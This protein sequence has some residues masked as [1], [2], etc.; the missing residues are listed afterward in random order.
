MGFKRR[1]RVVFLG[2]TSSLLP[3]IAVAHAVRLGA[4]WLETRAAVMGASALPVAGAL[5]ERVRDL[6][7]ALDAAKHLDTA[8]LEWADLIVTMDEAAR[9]ACPALPEGTQHRHYPFREPEQCQN[10]P[11]I[12][13]ICSAVE[14]RILGMI[15]GM[16]LLA[17]ASADEE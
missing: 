7:G 10:E 3:A 4:E 12:R 16:K 13:E 1:S 11:E 15:G 5:E 2:G 14:A 9:R 17:K 8:L 6:C